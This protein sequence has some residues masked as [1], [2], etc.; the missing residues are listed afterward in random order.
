MKHRAPMFLL[1]LTLTCS[2]SLPAQAPGKTV[3]ELPHLRNQVAGDLYTILPDI[4]ACN[5]GQLTPQAKQEFLR[6]INEVRA[7]HNLP[8]VIYDPSLE[9]ET[10]QAALIVAANRTM[11][12]TPP[13]TY[14]CWSKEGRVGSWNSNLYYHLYSAWAPSLTR[15]NR[16]RRLRE[17]AKRMKRNLPDA[18]SMVATWMIDWRI[19]TVGHRRWLLDPFVHRVAFARVD[20]VEESGDRVDH[21][22][23]AAINVIEGRVEPRYDVKPMFI[24]YPFGDYPA[25][26]FE[27]DWYLSFSLLVTGK[28]SILNNMV[29]YDGATI[30]MTDE[31]GHSL[32]V[33]EQKSNNDGY[34]IPNILMWKARDIR[35]GT[36]YRVQIHNVRIGGIPRSYAYSFKLGTP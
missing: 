20:Q 3:K 21:I 11:N 15:K 16:D 23:G 17:I 31:E 34:G 13:K 19:S 33:Y 30:H 9:P 25:D 6:T 29:H 18:R 32:S 4:P 8:A 12:H 2:Q 36:E 27:P 7:L 28:S 35:P 1:L 26:M 5:P 10:R 22:V 14:A 24:A